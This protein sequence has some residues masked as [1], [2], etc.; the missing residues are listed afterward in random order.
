MYLVRTP[1]GEIKEVENLD[2]GTQMQ[3]AEIYELLTQETAGVELLHR[4][5]E[6]YPRLIQEIEEKKQNFSESD[7]LLFNEEITRL[8]AEHAQCREQ[9]SATIRRVLLYTRYI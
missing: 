1:Q 3:Q 5:D 6:E 4:R 9:K 7:I 8:Q 2:E